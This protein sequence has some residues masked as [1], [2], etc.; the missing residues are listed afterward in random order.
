M[1]CCTSLPYFVTADRQLWSVDRLDSD[2]LLMYDDDDE[3][4][5]DDEQLMESKSLRH[6]LWNNKLAAPLSCA[7][8][9]R[10][11]DEM[12][13]S[14]AGPLLND[15][16]WSAGMLP[17]DL[18]APLPRR[19]G[20]DSLA[21]TPGWHDADVDAAVVCA[22]V[23]PSLVSPCPPHQSSTGARH[24]TS[25]P[26]PSTDLGTRFVCLLT[27]LQ[28]GVGSRLTLN[29]CWFHALTSNERMSQLIFL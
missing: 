3:T 6:G 8:P 19:S 2:E 5:S 23:D 25:A 7:P 13:P 22:A 10:A 17:A 21:V 16:M 11:D 26:P 27:R 1:A 12:P 29:R 24:V 15:C 18:K 4:G 28:G 14:G 20:A 9:P